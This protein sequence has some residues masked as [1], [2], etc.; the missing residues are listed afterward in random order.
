MLLVL[1][2]LST[3][4]SFVVVYY[5]STICSY[6]C[7]LLVAAMQFRFTAKPQERARPVSTGTV[8]GGDCDL[9]EGGPMSL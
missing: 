9:Q 5:C 2:L 3:G 8:S 7:S 1:L 4:M 6:Y